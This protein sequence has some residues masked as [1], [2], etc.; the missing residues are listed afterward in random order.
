[1]YEK[2]TLIFIKER[3]HAHSFYRQI[4][5]MCSRWSCSGCGYQESLSIKP[6]CV[7]Q[8]CPCYKISGS[9]RRKTSLIF[10]FF[11]SKL[12]LTTWTFSVGPR[13]AMFSVGSSI[14]GLDLPQVC[15]CRSSA[16]ST[17]QLRH[18][19]GVKHRQSFLSMQNYPV[20]SEIDLSI[21]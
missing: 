11:S 14:Q 18:H 21:F 5:P 9:E 3:I 12:W 19:A 4:N 13:A 8:E 6:E 2:C 15:F 1:M 10:P 17:T 20:F 16:S 7:E